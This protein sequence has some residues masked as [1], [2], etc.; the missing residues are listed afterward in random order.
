P[1]AQH[2]HF[3]IEKIHQ[4][5]H[6]DAR[7]FGG[8]FDDAFDELVTAPDGLAQ[9]ATAEV[10]EILA[11][12]LGEHGFL[13]LFDGS[14]N[15]AKDGAPTGQRFKAAA[16]AAAAFGPVDIND[17]MPDLAGGAVVAPIRFA[18]QDES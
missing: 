13:A 16:V 14:L 8:F 10:G 3:R 17:H 1:A 2:D 15:G 12:H 6:G 4:V 18:V 5:A 7:V 11:E 9:V